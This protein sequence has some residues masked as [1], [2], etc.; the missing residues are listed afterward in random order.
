MTDDDEHMADDGE[1]VTHDTPAWIGETFTSDAGWDHL[2]TLVD[3][4]NRMAGQDGEREALEATRDAFAEAGCRDARIEEFDLQGWIRG[5]AGIETPRG[6]QDCIALPRSPAG[7]ASGELVDLGAG[8]PEDFE[9]ADVEGKIVL[10]STT[11]PD[12]YER[13]IHRREKYYHAVEGG[14]AAF[15]F[16]NHVEGCLPPTG[17]VGTGDAPIGDIPAVGVSKE[18]GARLARRATGEDVSVSVTCETPE[19]TSGNA[20]AELGPETD[21]EIIVSSHV[22]AHDI[23]EGAMDN[24]AGTATIVEIAHAL[25]RREADLDTRVRFIAYGAEEVGLVGSTVESERADHDTIKA[26]V[27]VD[28]NVYGRTLQLTTH[29]FEELGEAAN[30]VSSH[31]DHPIETVPDLVPHSDHWPFVRHGVPGYMVAGKTE[32]RGRGF[33]HTFADTFE[34]LEARNLREQAILLTAL[35]ADL[36]EEGTEVEPRTEDEIA[37]ELEAANQAEGMKIT[38]DWPY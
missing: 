18:V 30:R 13:F 27:N 34:K 4:G 6:T 26:I 12:W 9:D 25:S 2:E 11:V 21:E 8:L 17:S 15:V 20:M 32:G 1:H 35:V 7:E 14:A 16:R 5:D 33:G 31:F 3:I 23:A 36:A 29:G 28:S 24:G 10:V 38:G 37:S 19:T 22:D